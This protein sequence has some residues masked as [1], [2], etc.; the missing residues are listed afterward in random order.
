MG[1][2]NFYL[3][4]LIQKNSQQTYSLSFNLFFTDTNSNTIIKVEMGYSDSKFMVNSTGTGVNAGVITSSG[5][6]C[7][8]L[9]ENFSILPFIISIS[10]SDENL[11][12][13]YTID[14][15]NVDS[16]HLLTFGTIDEVF[17]R[18][19]EYDEDEKAYKE[20]IYTMPEITYLTIADSFNYYMVS[21]TESTEYL[22]LTARYNIDISNPDYQKMY[23]RFP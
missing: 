2:V 16:S 17:A 20:H 21:L 23:S 18:K 1:L 4:L 22:S 11:L 10:D 3:N 19:T 12:C 14:P 8:K 13:K 15:V 7:G 6:Y 9:R 5:F